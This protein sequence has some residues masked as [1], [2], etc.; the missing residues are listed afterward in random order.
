MI[1]SE[2]TNKDGSTKENVKGIYDNVDTFVSII[3]D[4]NPNIS[5]D[6]LF[7]IIVQQSSNTI[8]MYKALNL[9]KE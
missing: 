4:N 8:V 9:F 2:I 7:N 3:I 1:E 5:L 6:S